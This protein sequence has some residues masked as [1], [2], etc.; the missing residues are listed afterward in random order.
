LALVF[1][2]EIKPYWAE[3]LLVVD[4]NALHNCVVSAVV[5]EHHIM[6]IGID[7]PNLGKVGRIQK[8]IAH[9]K[10]LSAKRGYSYCNRSTE[11]KSRLWRLWR[12]FEE[13]TARKLVR[14]A[15]QYKAAIV[16]HSPND[17]SIRALKEG[18]IV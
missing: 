7:M 17:K 13:V 15:R 2:R 11:L 8:K 18:A 14:L 6:T 5:G 3:R 9:I 10:R 16:L 4:L 1:A 12:P